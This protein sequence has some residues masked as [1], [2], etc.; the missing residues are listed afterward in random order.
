MSKHYSRSQNCAICNH[1]LDRVRIYSVIKKQY[2]ANSVNRIRTK[3]AAVEMHD[4]VCSSCV[5]KGAI[6]KKLRK[7]MLYYYILIDL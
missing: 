3:V 5:V 7:L 2:L 6:T 1:R 4:H